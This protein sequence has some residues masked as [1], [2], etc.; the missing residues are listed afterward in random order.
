MAEPARQKITFAEIRAAGVLGLLI[1][2]SDY[3]CSH[4]V[5]ISGDRWSDDVR[6]S[7]IEPLFTCPT[8]GRKGADV[9]PNFD[10]EQE[11]RRARL[12]TVLMMTRAFFMGGNM[13][14][15]SNRRPADQ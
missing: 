4:S 9:R 7:D 6:L 12:V 10:C 5:A 13:P 15:D 2:C 1:Y 3:R 11:A 14:S 8:C